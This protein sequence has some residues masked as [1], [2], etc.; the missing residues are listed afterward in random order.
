M[1]EPSGC[2]NKS[3]GRKNDQYILVQMKISEA[4]VIINLKIV[5]HFHIW[6]TYINEK[7]IEVK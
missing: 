6:K 7:D 4:V 3:L 2:A 1:E 5:I